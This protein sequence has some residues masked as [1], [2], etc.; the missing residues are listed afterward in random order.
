MKDNFNILRDTAVLQAQTRQFEGLVETRHSLLRLRPYN[1]HHWV[2]LAVAY[3]LN[4]NLVEAKQVLEYIEGF[5]RVRAVSNP[6]TLIRLT[7]LQNVGSSDVELSELLMYH[8]RVLEDMG[9]FQSALD[10]V[11]SNDR[12]NGGQMLDR[13]ASMEMKGVT[14]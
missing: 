1:R 13:I 12:S 4:G 5:L 7:H 6:A 10:M 3:Q 8:V 11:E 14:T 9:D 2:G